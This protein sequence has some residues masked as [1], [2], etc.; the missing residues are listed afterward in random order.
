MPRIHSRP[1]QRSTPGSVCGPFSLARTSIQGSRGWGVWSVRGRGRLVSGRWLEAGQSNPLRAHTTPRPSPTPFLHE[2][3]TPLHI[4]KAPHPRRSRLPSPLFQRS[5]S[6]ATPVND[7]VALG[8]GSRVLPR[9]EQRYHDA[10]HDGQHRQHRKRCAHPSPRFLLT[11]QPCFIV[12]F[13]FFTSFPPIFLTTISFLSD[14]D[15]RA[16]P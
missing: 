7:P 5:H 16:S 3:A 1:A 8:A 9:L 6:F 15:L 2:P 14:D 13:S 12:S 11:R 10:P 4:P